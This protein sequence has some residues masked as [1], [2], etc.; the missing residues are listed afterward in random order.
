MARIRIS[1]KFVTP[2][3]RASG[4][5]FVWQ[6]PSRM[7]ALGWK[8]QALLISDGTPA[9]LPVALAQAGWLNA[10]Y[11][12]LAEG[13]TDAA[14]LLAAAWSEGREG[15]S[16]GI[17]SPACPFIIYKFPGLDTAAPPARAGKRSLAHLFDLYMQSPD[18]LNLR[19]STRQQ[20]R[21]AMDDFRKHIG[22]QHVPSFKRRKCRMLY[23][24]LIR[25]HKSQ[26][27]A[28]ARMRV[29]SVC[30][31]YAQELE[32]IEFNPLTRFRFIP[33]DGRIR[34][35]TELETAALL[36]AARRKGRIDGVLLIMAAA[37][38]GQ[39]RGDLCEGLSLAD[40]NSGRFAL[41]QQKS[42]AFIN[43]QILFELEQAGREAVSH[44]ENLWGD[45]DRH[46]AAAKLKRHNCWY[47]HIKHTPLLWNLDSTLPLD[48][49]SA[50]RLFADIRTEAMADMP[51]VAD[52]HLSDYRDYMVT[53]LFRAGCSD[54]EAASIT[55]H[56]E[57]SIAM[58]RKH[59]FDRH[60][61]VV[62]NNA[63]TKLRNRRAGMAS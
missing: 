3:Q 32:W 29:L 27:S 14:R 60:D 12:A 25:R 59:Y 30:L 55:G 31:S 26:G 57:K 11:D 20:Y 7:K 36:A 48:R 28:N 40:F 56:S 46:F 58:K 62:S 39:R 15:A 54:P 61:P 17:S 35:P 42:G 23:E 24:T 18:Y 34:V 41:P 43:I 19:R 47:R 52:I 9:S 33:V 37:L 16:V 2:R 53:E 10:I 44:F 6:P 5:Y 8:A 50:T 22:A 4:E 63:M 13:R 38:L 1:E 49:Y 45:L 51:S 21:N